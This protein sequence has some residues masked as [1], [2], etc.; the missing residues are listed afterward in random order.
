MGDFA[1]RAVNDRYFLER[2]L[3]DGGMATVWLARDLRHDRHV[4]L[5]VIRPELAGVI[6]VN[7]FLREIQLTAQLQ[8]PNIVPLLD[9]GTVQGTDGTL[10]PW[11]AM[12]YLEGE[13]L[14]TRLARER[15]LPLDDAL[16]ITEA[17]AGALQ[18]AHREN[19]VHRDIKPENVFLANGH[20]YV[21]DFGIAKA[22]MDTGA[23]RLTGTGISIGT[24]AYMSPEQAAGDAVD[25]RSD[26]YSLATVLYEMLVGETPFSGMT[27]QSVLARR[28]AES[29]RPIRTVR[30]GVP[31]TVEAAVLKAL[32]RAP[33]DRY[34][35]VAAF[36]AGLRS[37]TAHVSRRGRHTLLVGA[38]AVLLVALATLAPRVVSQR[39][40]PE[41]AGG[42]RA[43]RSRSRYT[44]ARCR[45]FPSAP[46]KARTTR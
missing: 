25:A 34:A 35:D 22:L 33:G 19:I 9:S 6:G 44:R 18:A 36:V 28:L 14:R 37:A 15:Q 16:C 10:L 30:A 5:K 24:A 13:S 42:S 40:G 21:L 12:S 39:R 4:A 27:L 20:V 46:T 23:E 45:A 7:R 3:G 1:E 38:V 41:T 29:A 26:Q 31:P 2:E 32:E 43:I 11:Y 8:H 17:V